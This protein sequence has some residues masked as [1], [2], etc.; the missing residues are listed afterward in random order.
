MAFRVEWRARARRDLQAF[1]DYLNPLNPEAASRYVGELR[2]R[3]NDL[4]SMPNVG[5]RFRRYRVIVVRNHLVFYLVD[6]VSATVTIVAIIDA[7]R[8]LDSILEH[9]DSH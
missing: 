4:S 8:D 5:R 3:C 1:I 9:I 6:N 7:R 2:S